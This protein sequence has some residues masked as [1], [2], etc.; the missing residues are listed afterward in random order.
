VDTW[1]WQRR[2]QP[3]PPTKWEII[4][5]QDKGTPF[6]ADVGVGEDWGHLNK[7]RQRA[8]VGKVRRN[9]Q[10]MKEVQRVKAEARKAAK[11]GTAGQGKKVVSLE[12]ENHPHIQETAVL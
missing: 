9:V 12:A 8:R 6:G 10:F 3:R 1:L 7:R 4:K 5:S 11:A 2:T